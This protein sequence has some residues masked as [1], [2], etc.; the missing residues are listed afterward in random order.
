LGNRPALADRAASAFQL[1]KGWFVGPVT[2]PRHRCKRRLDGQARSYNAHCATEP[3][4]EFAT[5][6]PGRDR[7]GVLVQDDLHRQN[8]DDQ[9]ERMI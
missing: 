3:L 8:D 2:G 7:P 6:T 9:N 5:K 1:F 4:I